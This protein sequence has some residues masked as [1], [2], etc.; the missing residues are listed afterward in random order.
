MSKRSEV[1]N[2]D[3]F[4]NKF[5]NKANIRH[6]NRYDY[7][8][9]NYVNSITK[10]DII[11]MEHGIFSVRPDAHV[12]KVGCPVCNGGI[13][14]SG[15]D[16]ISKCIEKHNDRYDYS[17]V[18]YVDSSKKVE[19]ICK[20]H[21]S[22]LMTPSKHLM[23]QGCTK[24]VGTY[25]KNTEEFKIVANRVHGML[26]DYSLVEYKN[27]RIKVMIICNKH[28]IFE[29]IP[30]SHLRGH[31]CASC[32]SSKG[33]EMIEK[34]LKSFGLN[35]NKGFNFKECI[36]INGGSLPFDFYLSDL[37]FLIEYDGRQHYEPV[38][39]FGGDPCLNTLKLNDN[40][41]NEWCKENKIEL[42]RIKYNNIE[43]D[44]NVLYDFINSLI[45]KKCIELDRPNLITKNNIEEYLKP[46]LFDIKK[47]I[48]IRKEFI[49][50]INTTYDD[51]IEYEHKINSSE[52]DIFLPK[53]NI[54]FKL[55]GL[56][57]NSEVNSEKN[58]QLETYNNY[59]NSGFKI[60]QIYED[61]W[62]SKKEIIKSRINNILNK[63]D[64]LYARNCEIRI[65]ETKECSDF[66]D[67]SHLQGK[68]GSSIKLGLYN[69]GELV[70]VMTFGTL[71]K[72]LGQ[73][74][75]ENAYELLRFCN[76][77]NTNVLGSASKLFNY[78]IKNYNPSYIV[79][80]AD[81]CW[82]SNDNIYSKLNMEY[83]HESK[84]SYFYIIGD[85]RKGRFAYRK[86]QLLLCGYSKELT[87]HKIC[88]S[89]N[90]FR[91]YDC[92][93]F[94]YEWNKKDDTI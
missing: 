61:V 88:L 21:G 10:V 79:S 37:N 43:N 91:I 87:E 44:L 46:S 70:S 78:F 49:D 31:G 2:I 25:K 92:G 27:N 55:L 9:V 18:N 57:K 51:V 41:R 62:I 74:S 53:I 48:S 26:Y 66:L 5:I 52:C 35:Y 8:L 83:S 81:K 64:K 13:K 3:Y 1:K 56:Y 76:K 4:K 58:T 75:K 30:K 77:L 7:S 29:Q 38:S 45:N 39:K 22:F 67:K 72:N 19:I 42:I 71:R 24:C 47:Y 20:E 34:I 50:F 54:G 40:I 14:Y 80:Y 60:I 82:S 28:G 65:V 90:I 63:S 94:K 68:I 11:C 33:E 89:N 15:E 86:D 84:P 73:T 59:T 32:I 36:G 23:G 17:L 12:R 69:G 6:N 85:T 16:F 93:S